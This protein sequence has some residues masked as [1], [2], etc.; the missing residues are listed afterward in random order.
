MIRMNGKIAMITG[1]GCG[2]GRAS[3]LLMAKEG[4]KVVLT[5]IQ[6]DK[7]AAVV[8]EIRSLN[9]EALHFTHNVTDE[10][11]WLTVIEKT[12]DRFGTINVLVNSA[13]ISS[14]N[15]TMED[16]DHV[17]NINLRGSFLGMKHIIPI[18]QNAGAGSIVNICSLAGIT[19]GGFNGYTASKGGIRAV[20]RAAAVDYAKN[21]IRV[22]SIYPGIIITPM[23]EGI[24]HHEQIKQHFEEKTPIPRFGTPEDIAYGVIYLA[25]DEAGF[26][27]GAELVI[28]GGTTAL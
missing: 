17:T 15:D 27:T 11:E 18:M 1:A 3:A 23:T 16:W 14:K 10:S 28:D 12:V 22:N 7:L 13:G 25:S 6:A 8:E 26:V 24:L 19:G 5:D 9:G 20:S 4:A 21:N 2:I